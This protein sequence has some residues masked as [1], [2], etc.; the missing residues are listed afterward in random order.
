MSSAGLQAAFDQGVIAELLDHADV[1]HRAL[2]AARRRAAAAPAVAAVAYQEGLDAAWLRP[3]ANH[4]QV[5]ALDRVP[6]ELLAEMTLGGGSAGEHHETAGFLVDAV[7]GP[8][9]RQRPGLAVRQQRR[10][11]V[12]QR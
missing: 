2:P 4:R 1:C 11:Q 7:D 5:A 3:P 8:D 12:G 9:A 10:Q 6:A